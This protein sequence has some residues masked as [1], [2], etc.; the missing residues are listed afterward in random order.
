MKIK[1]M[2]KRDDE[3][4][5]VFEFCERNFFNEMKDR[6]S[7]NKDFTEDEIKQIVY[8]ILSGLNYIHKNGYCHRDIKPENL[9]IKESSK[10]DIKESTMVIADFGLCKDLRSSSQHTDDVSTRW[11][12][13]PE[14]CLSST[15][16]NQ[17]IDLWALAC[18]M[19]EITTGKPLFPGINDID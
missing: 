10:T 15:S 12:R 17:T 4:A 7:N 5:I 1:E 8:Q 2:V 6:K 16:Y 11:Y 14:L 18:I 13:A 9:L 3:L 19:V